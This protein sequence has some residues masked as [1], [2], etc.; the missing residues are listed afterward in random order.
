MPR[1][2]VMVKGRGGRPVVDRDGVQIDRKDEE[3]CV[4]YLRR[5]A[6][7]ESY[8]AGELELTVFDGRHTQKYSV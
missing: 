1:I 7:E 4:A 8:K 6:K 5:V 3:E 2:K